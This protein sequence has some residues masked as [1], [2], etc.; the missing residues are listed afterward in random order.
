MIDA[1]H[2]EE[3]AA[4]GH[5][6]QHRL[7]LNSLNTKEKSAIAEVQYAHIVVDHNILNVSSRANSSPTRL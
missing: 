3:A 2:S 1:T 6:E 4:G 7:H 5:T